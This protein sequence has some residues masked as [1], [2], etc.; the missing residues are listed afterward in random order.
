MADILRDFF[1]EFIAVIVAV[2]FKY[3]GAIEVEG[4]YTQNRL[5]V[6]N[7]SSATQ[8]HI[9]VILRNDIDKS[10]DTLGCIEK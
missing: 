1:N 3:N 2:N 9:K 8:V 5:S 4:K 6:H 10:L 7:V